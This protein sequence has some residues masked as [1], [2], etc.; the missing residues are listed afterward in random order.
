MP[1]KSAIIPALLIWLCALPPVD[2][3]LARYCELVVADPPGVRSS[4][5]MRVTYLGTN[6]YRFETGKHVL[7]VDPYFTRV[8]LSA[9][10]FRSPLEPN[11][12]EIE[13]AADFFAK[14]EL[15]L[16]THGHVDH[17]FDVPAIMQMTSAHLLASRTAVDL[18]TAAGTSPARC[19]AVAPGEV[20]QIGPWKIRVLPA[21]HDRVFPIGIPF[22]GPRKG[23]D[24]PR[25][26]S[27]WVCGEPL[28]F[29]I[30]AA[31]KRI[32]LDS[33]GTPAQLPSNDI[34]PVYLAILGVALPDTRARFSETVRRLRPR[35]VLPSHQDNFFRPLDRGFAFGPLTDFPRIQRDDE[36]EKLPGRL[37]LLDYFR[38]WT[39][40]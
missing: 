28:A 23:S 24:P 29:L 22:P 18:A 39:L 13:N 31:G 33:G 35:F 8:G 25:R 4:L 14:A 17:L 15:I 36:R 27:D 32:Y 34:A 30:E 11:I 40:P 7:L 37:I 21:T 19:V 9:F 26:A 20:R 16:A 3:G 1:G 12:A 38:P 2:A 10:L 6:G 5:G